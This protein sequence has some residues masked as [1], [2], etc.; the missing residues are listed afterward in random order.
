MTLKGQLLLLTV[1]F[2]IV[3][4]L[5]VAMPT[6][7]PLSAAWAQDDDDGGDDDDDGGSGSDDDDDDRSN[8]AQGQ[9]G[10]TQPRTQRRTT[11]RRQAPPPPV[12]LPSFAAGEIVAIGLSADDLSRLV[13]RGYTVIEERNVPAFGASSVRLA[14]P[15]GTSL[16]DARGE[17]RALPSGSAADF[18]HYY[19]TDETIE[20]AVCDGPH[21]VSFA[22]IG[23]TP[24]SSPSS[25]CA[26]LAPIGVI[27]TGINPDH[28]AFTGAE[29]EVHRLSPDTLDPSRAIHGTAVIALLVGGV[30]SRSPGLVPEAP[31]IAVDAFHR[32]GGDE[33]SDVFTL[34]Q[35]LD[36][37]AAKGVRVVNM[38]LSGPE[39]VVLERA[40]A[41]LAERNV[42]IVAAAGN[43]GP[44]SGPAFP[45]A[46][47]D[48]IAVTAVDRFGR[49]YRRAAQGDHIDL[50]APGVEV[51]TAASIS[52]A[53]PKTGTSFAAP[54]VTAAAAEMLAQNPALTAPE[55]AAQLAGAARDLGE[56]GRDPVY[57]DGLVQ[58][59]A[60][61]R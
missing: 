21:C 60:R 30:E 22:Q 49:V 55:V 45:A 31:V 14:V 33:R 44:R 9:P 59:V 36:L 56:T 19:R 27:D 57:G 24:V 54:F 37:L 16:D 53:R 48:V 2:G 35:G 40:I 38:S 26:A 29:L 17:V 7:S 61:C 43:G 11:Q 50:A 5:G 46:Y 13:A 10:T 39:N 23:W 3:T 52:G 15:D 58:A 18:N 6:L 41:T 28:Q 34:V 47:R 8:G 32:D 51:W 1:L 4:F 20:P 42:V 12:E 25:T